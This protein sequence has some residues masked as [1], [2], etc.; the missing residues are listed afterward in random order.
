MRGYVRE[1]RTGK[2]SYTVDV[3]KVDG[4]RK[5]VEKG[6]FSSRSD[7]EQAL[8][9][10]LAELATT[11][12]I[13]T[14]T[15]K[16]L[17]EVFNE[18]IST[19]AVLTRKGGTITKHKSVFKNRINPV[20]GYRY[21]KTIKPQ[22]IDGF[23]AKLISD[24]YSEGYAK[25]IYNTI[26]V[27]FS[28]AFQCGYLKE[29][30]AFKASVPKVPKKEID[31]YTPEQIEAL[32]DGLKNSASLVP[33]TISLYT[34]MRAGEVFGLR[35]RDI[36]FKKNTI[37]IN[38][39]M[40]VETS[41]YCIGDTKTQSSV[42]TIKM[43]AHLA[44]F[45]QELKKTQ[46]FNK[47]VYGELWKEN[48]VYSYFTKKVE[49]V[50]DFVNI[51]QDGS[52]LTPSSLKHVGRV[53]KALNIDWRFHI[54]RHTHATTLLENGASIKLVQER[55]GHARPDITL[56]VYSHVTNTHEKDIIDSIPVFGAS[57]KASDK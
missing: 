1:Y 33:V 28:Y 37:S 34:G 2:W 39:Q 13:F 30:V 43:P 49:T 11:G 32:L 18:F 16:T 40:I 44:N 48:K 25:N 47:S 52:M 53:A 54:L 9:I 23:I 21:I 55:L 22:D 46:K 36:D 35:W 7:A 41:R 56:K 27:T 8:S 4:K 5:K 3:G 45:L 6:G 12:E 15:E 29:N 57:D 38:K 14:P 24:G 10:K 51:K 31:V 19:K 50:E 26:F 42:R 20:L 17:E